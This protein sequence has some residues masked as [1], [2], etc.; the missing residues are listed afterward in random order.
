[1]DVDPE[2]ENAEP[3]HENKHQNNTRSRLQVP[4]KPYSTPF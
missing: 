1:M 4:N 3:K 2:D